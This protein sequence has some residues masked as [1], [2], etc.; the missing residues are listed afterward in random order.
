MDKNKANVPKIRFPGFTAPW[1]QHKLGDESMEIVAGGDIDKNKIVDSGKYPVLA[2]ALTNDGIVGYYKNDFRIKAPAVTV[3]GRGDVGHAK[4]RKVDFTPVV[5]LLAVKTKHDVDFLEN[6]INKHEVLVESTGVP[7]L[8]VPQL[9]KYKIYFPKT[10]DEEKVMGV[11]FK[12]LDNLI[13][14]HQRKLNHLQDKKKS[15]LQK[16]F[17]KNGEDFPELRFPGFTHP[18][19]Q[20]KFSDTFTNIP[21]NTLARAELNYNSGLAKNVHYGDVLIKFGELLDVEKDEIPYITDGALVN[22]FRSSKLQNGD[23]IIADAAEDET[24]G[25]CTELVNVGEKIVISGLHTIPCRPTLSFASGYLG[26]F[27][28]SYAYHNQL[29]RLMQGTKVSS[30]SKSALQD[31]FIFHPFD[32]VEQ[33]KISELFQQLNKLITLHQ[34][35]LNHLQEQKKALLQQMFI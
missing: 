26:Y 16:M 20:R 12:D 27:M 14:I 7:Q 8:T 28:N 22:K 32:I 23:V 11:F 1:E 25:K 19:E 4:A 18:W 35:K 2:N 33:K 10:D 29:L 15:L 17:P 3:T 13:T 31:T 24:V 6:A 30:I 9:S 21:N 5:R 34:R